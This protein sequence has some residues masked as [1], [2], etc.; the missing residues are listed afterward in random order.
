MKGDFTRR[1]FRR[2]Q[3]YRGVLLQQGRVA[4]D[5]DWN[6]QVDI[7]DHL[8]R[9]TTLDTVGRHGAPAGA[10]GMEILCVNGDITT[11]PC[12]AADLRISKGRYYVDGILCENERAVPLEAQPDLPGV[13]LDV[14]PGR[15]VA[16]LDVWAEHVTVVERPALREVALGGPDTATRSRTIWQV[17]LVRPDVAPDGCPPEDPPFTPP[18][19]AGRPGRL[20]SRAKAPDTEP[21]PC[22]LPPAARYRRLENQLYRVEIRTGSGPKGAPT[23]LWS[24]ENGSV[25]ARLLTVAGNELTI[26]APGRDE[27]LGFADRDWVEV[28]D[29][30]RV[31]RGEPGFLA[32]LGEVDGTQLTVGRWAGGTQPADDELTDGKLVR[33]WDSAGELTLGAGWV[34]LED[35]VEV[36]F[37]P[38]RTYRTGDYWLIPARSATLS[39]EPVDPDLAGNVEWPRRRNGEPAYRPPIG[40]KH[41]YAPL[42]IMELGPDGWRRIGDC[43]NVFPPLTGLVDVEYAGGDGQ[44]TL[45]G[46]PVPQPLEISVTDGAGPVRGALIHF[47]AD[48]ADGRLAGTR[49][50]LPGSTVSAVD[51][52]TGPDG[53]ARCFWQPARD[54]NRLS[55]R[56]TAG[57]VGGTAAGAPVHFSA[58]LSVA[59]RVGYD[60]GGCTAFAGTDN[61]QEALDRLVAARS[62]AG[63]GGD[64][65]AGPPGSELPLPVEVLVRSECGPVAGAQVRFTVPSGVVASN[66][67]GFAAGAPTIDVTTGADGVARC[68]W[69]LGADDPVQALTA[70]LLPGAAPTAEP[71]RLAFT[72]SLE[73]G[74]DDAPGLHVTE[75]RVGSQQ[76]LQNDSLLPATALVDGV[77][78]ILDGRPDAAL[79]NGK[80]VLT[81]TVDLPYPFSQSDRDLWHPGQTP[82]LTDLIGTIPLTLAGNVALVEVTPGQPMI[83]WTP[84]AGSTDFLQRLLTMMSEFNRGDRAL[85]H[86]TL[87]GRAIA[88]DRGRVVNGLAVGRPDTGGRT[89]L[90]LPTVD[91]VHGADFTLW[92]WLVESLVDFVLVP[93]R[94]GLLRLKSVR[95]MIDLSVP[96]EALRDRL[97]AGVRVTEGRPQ[98]T[99]AAERAARR[100]FAK[101]T[102][103]RLVVVADER[104]ADAAGVLQDALKQVRVEV[105]V[106]PA[107]DPAAVAND[108]VQAKDQLDAVLTDDASIQPITDLVGFGNAIPL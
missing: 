65:Q 106:I 27:R 5:A 19:A 50:A 8:D 20:R 47:A 107:A 42:A 13:A 46:Q 11:G 51:V 45:P 64:G 61:V 72:A 74:R 32:Q 104:Y 69:R 41:H 77:A 24:R 30:A 40:I 44:E 29:S 57:L 82:T 98:D 78:V 73:R 10:A 53:L 63:V 15:Y 37:D 39:G 55:Q 67:T 71:T 43:R 88:T 92:F 1:T 80:P 16:Y 103:R 38:A 35:G 102:R 66:T 28:T 89:E 105:E 31:R 87:T 22:V 23:F 68:S 9:T 70:E 62:L 52:V 56:V 4:L 3:H 84:R 12:A 6:E 101:G 83:T 26:E 76:I 48:H 79:V 85:C 94:A 58:S 18:T 108:R 90:V 95:D 75:V 100:G 93:T 54:L 34:G 96:R 7:S 25:A 59:D 17:R 81:L 36:E 49:A 86:L 21:G 2:R 60:P 99:D 33:R 97:R 91:D 14:R